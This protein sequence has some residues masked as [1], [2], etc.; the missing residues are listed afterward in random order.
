MEGCPVGGLAA[1]TE[2]ATAMDRVAFPLPSDAVRAFSDLLAWHRT[3]QE[4][5]EALERHGRAPPARARPL[6]RH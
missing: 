6:R 1:R 5:A 2:D 3:A 4:A